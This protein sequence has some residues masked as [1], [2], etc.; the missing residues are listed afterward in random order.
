MDNNFDNNF[1]NVTEGLSGAYEGSDSLKINNTGTDNNIQNNGFVNYQ[2]QPPQ[3]PV[4][5]VMS[6]TNEVAYYPESENDEKKSRRKGILKTVVAIL[7]VLGISAGSI[8]GYIALTDNG[9]NIPFYSSESRTDDESSSEAEN[10]SADETATKEMPSLLQLAAKE[11]ALSIPEIVKKVSPS[12]VGI[13]SKLYNGTSTGTGIIMTSDGYI[14]TNGHVVE[15]A[16]TITVV[17]SS[18]KEFEE[19]EARLIGIDTKTD[20]AVIKVDKTELIP[21]EFGL[22][23]ELEVG[24]LAIAIGN[25]LGF[26]LAGS[27]TGGLI[28]ALNREL[29][30]EDKQ[31]TLIQTDAAINPGNSGGPLVNSYGQVIGINSVKISSSYSTSVEGLGFAIP[32]DEAK[33]IID[34]LILYGYVK[35]RPMIGLSG[36]DITA[37]IARYYNLPQ[38]VIVRFIEPDSG[39]EKGGIKIGDIIIGINDQPIATM[40][41]LNKIKDTFKAGVTIKLTVYRDGE[42]ID[43]SVVLSEAKQQ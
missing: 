8:G 17:I 33:P 5:P 12:V 40:S 13:S 4:L 43:V 29:T 19:C 1:D 36:E 22:S 15:N 10:N 3:M 9:R 23:D 35:G 38:G 14:I 6:S 30:V 16:T 42:T 18:D 20:L 31:M 25:P 37:V 2:N 11:N 39:A 26:D 28:S 21:A 24:E 32:I 41:E 34:D 27:V 7:C